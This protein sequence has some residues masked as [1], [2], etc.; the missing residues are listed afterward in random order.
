[1]TQSGIERGPGGHARPVRTTA[2]VAACIL[3]IGSFGLAAPAEAAVTCA[4][5]AG[6]G[7]VTLDK[8]DAVTIRHT[9]DPGAQLVVHDD[10][11]GVDVDCNNGTPVLVADV[12]TVVVNGADDDE[13]VTID[14][15][16]GQFV[17]VGGALV[18]FEMNLDNTPNARF[19]TLRILGTGGDDT[20]KVVPDG[21]GF[22]VDLNNDGTADV[23]LGGVDALE[24]EGGAG[25]DTL[26]TTALPSTVVA[27]VTLVGGAGDDTLNGGDGN[28]TIIGGAG[29]DVLNG[30]AGNDLLD[31]GD[32]DDTLN[33]GDGDD[34]LLG[35]DGID[36]LNGDAGNDT[37]KGQLGDDV[38]NGGDG[39]DSLIGGAGADSFDGGAGTDTADFSDETGPVIVNLLTGTAETPDGTETLVGIENIIGTPFDDDLTGDNNDNMIEGLDGDDV[40]RGLGGHDNLKG[41]EGADLI[42]GGLD[43]DDIDGDSGADSINGGEGDDHIKGHGGADTIDGDGDDDWI[44]GNGDED[45]INGDE[46]NDHIDGGADDDTLNGNDGSDHIDGGGGEEVM[47]GGDGSDTLNGGDDDDTMNGDAGSDHVDGDDGDDLV[48]G[49]ANSDHVDGGDGDD[50][51]N[52]DGGNDTVL[53]GF[54]ADTMRGDAGNDLLNGQSGDDT[55]YGDAGVNTVSFQGSPRAVTVN[56]ADGTATG[57]GADT[58]IDIQNVIGSDNDDTLTGDEFRN[59]I[60]GEDGDDVID[61][62]AARIEGGD[63]DDTITLVLDSSDPI[64]LTGGS[65]TA[66]GGDTLV[67]YLRNAADTVHVLQP[68]GDQLS[69]VVNGFD[70]RI[71]GFENLEIDGRGGADSF[72]VHDLA[73]AGLTSFTIDLGHTFT[74]NGT[75]TIA[76]TVATPSKWPG[77]AAPSS[78]AARSPTETV[79]SKPGG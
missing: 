4:F 12:S 30:G 53:G 72:L 18:R 7:T 77:R 66:E 58:L 43:S 28:D 32:G 78:R 1:M 57:W 35:G 51:I 38:L 68:G 63:G 65:H 49:G 45:T 14:Q 13:T 54:G 50:T 36:T 31:G 27:D 42:R 10:T 22:G 23:T 5:D 46:G 67:L 8:N 75:K 59:T 71:N 16:N 9:D 47:H 44:D 2:L 64:V 34:T 70:R 40:I 21:A 26:D 48:N 39:D 11:A 73:S 55:M 74:V 52:G 79:V 25:L 41:D 62:P 6:T 61:G 69:I 33:G 60:R 56:L 20:M 3:T 29:N 37:L 24:L 19:D 15:S 17:G 76:T